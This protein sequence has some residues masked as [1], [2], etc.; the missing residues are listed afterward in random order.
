M[1]INIKNQ[2]WDKDYTLQNGG[3]SNALQLQLMYPDA[4]HL[5]LPIRSRQIGNFK[6]NVILFLWQVQDVINLNEPFNFR[7]KE[8]KGKVVVGVADINWKHHKM[9]AEIRLRHSDQRS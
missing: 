1:Q 4:T 8:Y 9:L 5:S 3:S 2:Q 7:I 6:Q